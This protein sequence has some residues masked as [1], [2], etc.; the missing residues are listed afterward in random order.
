[1]PPECPAANQTRRRR[2]PSRRHERL[3]KRP[4]V[5]EV[6]RMISATGEAGIIGG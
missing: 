1:M 4:Q 2:T 5:D 3:E 6:V